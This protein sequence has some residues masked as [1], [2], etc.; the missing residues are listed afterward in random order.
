MRFQSLAI[1]PAHWVSLQPD[2]SMSSGL[3]PQEC[4]PKQ[5]FLLTL[6]LSGH[7]ITATSETIFLNISDVAIN[8][9]MKPLLGQCVG[10]AQSPPASHSYPLLSPL[11]FLPT[12]AEQL[13]ILL[14]SQHLYFLVLY[15]CEHKAGFFS[16]LASF[17]QHTYFD[18]QPYFSIYSSILFQCQWFSV[19]GI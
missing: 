8:I 10:H 13:Q 7:F 17:T 5:T 18:T 9:L 4:D 16:D 3:N 11:L 6:L 15:E 14:L 12:F 1:L 19:M 2:Q